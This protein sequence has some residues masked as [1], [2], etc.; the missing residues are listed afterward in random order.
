MASRQIPRD[1]KVTL[2]LTADE[3][4]AL[5]AHADRH[6]LTASA[7]ARQGLRSAGVLPP[8][9]RTRTPGRRA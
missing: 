4:A 2:R 9:D 3:A 1:V 8:A 7:A 6:G 5:Q